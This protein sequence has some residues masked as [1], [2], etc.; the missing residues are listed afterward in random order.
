MARKI[1]GRIKTISDPSVVHEVEY[2]H[3]GEWPKYVTFCSQIFD[4]SDK[5]YREDI[6][7]SKDRNEKVTCE[8]CREALVRNG[9]DPDVVAVGKQKRGPAGSHIT[10][11]RKRNRRSV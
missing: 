5:K 1:L 10:P 6:S 11:A 2:S 9:H 4:M 8:L 3:E 7:I